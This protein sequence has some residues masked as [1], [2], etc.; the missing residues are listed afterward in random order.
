LPDHATRT[1]ETTTQQD[2]KGSDHDRNDHRDAEDGRSTRDGGT[3][4]DGISD[5]DQAD[6]PHGG[7]QPD[8]DQT[9]RPRQGAAVGRPERAADGSGSSGTDDPPATLIA[10]P[11]GALWVAVDGA[12]L[13]EVAARINAACDALLLAQLSRE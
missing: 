2:P 1:P 9:G 10:G 13:R 12:D 5:G 6:G 11:D 3:N 4:E 7:D 8:T